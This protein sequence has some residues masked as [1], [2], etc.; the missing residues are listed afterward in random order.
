MRFVQ[1][2]EIRS[3]PPLK[4]HN[5]GKMSMLIFVTPMVR[6]YVISHLSSITHQN[7]LTCGL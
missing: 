3:T 7:R 6:R 5:V 2:V 1:K 4:D